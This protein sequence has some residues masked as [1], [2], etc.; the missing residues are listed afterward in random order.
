MFELTK[1]GAISVELTIR[2]NTQVVAVLLISAAASQALYTALYLLA[3]E[4]DRT[5]IWGAEAVIFTLLSAF[6]ASALVQSKTL[7][8]GWGA[9]L[10][11]A[12]LNV[13]QVG[14]GLT[15]FGP[16]FEAAA[17][18]EALAH[19][20]G[21]VVAYSFF[22]YN[23]AKV[24]LALAAVMFGLATMNSGGIS[25][26]IGGAAALFGV[27]AFFANAASMAMG[28]DVFGELPLAGGSGV[29]ATLL[30]AL[31]VTR[32]VGERD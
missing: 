20:A 31:C 21:S 6:A 13:V 26:V 14:V 2:R 15:M 24:L 10:A 30:L 22:V 27:V 4:V 3:P 5:P 25:K 23:A 32:T 8:L 9:I 18:V 1:S 11:S 29:V 12:I 16:F 28:R 17:E 19:A 7:S